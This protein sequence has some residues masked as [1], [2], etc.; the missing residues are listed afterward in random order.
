MSRRKVRLHPSSAGCSLFLE[1]E[2]QE[3]TYRLLAL[4]SFSFLHSNNRHH[5]EVLMGEDMAVINEVA[6]VHAAEIHQQLN[7][8]HRTL[9]IVCIVP[10][11]HFNH[12]QELTIDSRGLGRSID[13]E[14]VLREH[15]EVDLM[16]VK[17]VVFL[18]QVLNDPFLHASLRGNDG[19]RIV[20]VKYHRGL[21]GYGDKELRRLNFGELQGA[22]DA[23]AY[24]LGSPKP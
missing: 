3:R 12:V 6:D 19:R 10:E 13:L 17:F 11:G 23:V 7:I 1:E 22:D 15:F 20:A 8:R 21:S 2:V 4:L 24:K 14:V 9:G 5:A 16:H 18:S